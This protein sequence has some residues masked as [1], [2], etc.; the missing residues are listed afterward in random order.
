MFR[1]DRGASIHGNAYGADGDY[2]ANGKRNFS[3]P[4]SATPARCRRNWPLGLAIYGNGGMNTDYRPQPFAAFGASGKAG[5]DLRNSSSRRPVAFQPG[6]GATRIGA[7][8]TFAY[9]RF[10]A[11]GPMSPFDNPRCRRPRVR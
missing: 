4:N 7:A 2:S 6:A 3:S 8:V 11:R 9:Q 5:I 1:P 10:A